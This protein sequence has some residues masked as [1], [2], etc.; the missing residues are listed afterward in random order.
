ME[1]EG[2]RGAGKRKQ[3]KEEEIKR[4]GERKGRKRRWKEE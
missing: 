3:W 1:G 2:G 4:G